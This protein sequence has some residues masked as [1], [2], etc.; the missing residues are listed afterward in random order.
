MEN[1]KAFI[2]GSIFTLSNKLQIIGDRLDSNLT[3]KQWLLLA[4]IH[5]SRN[6]HP[7][8]SEVAGIIGNSRQNVKK[9]LLILE[10]LGF[11]KMGNDS[12]D[13]RVQKVKIT[14]KCLDYLK[15]REKREL[16]FLEQLFEGFEPSEIQELIHGISKLEKNI[17]SIA[18]LKHDEEKE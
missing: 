16:K 10:K 2:F 12:N 1:A 15:Q 6:E 4:G 18:R 7:T 3:V 14:E 8:I 13:A 17:I 9:M 11:V 5:N